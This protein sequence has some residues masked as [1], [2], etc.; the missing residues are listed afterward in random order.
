MRK[1]CC[2]MSTRIFNTFNKKTMFKID[3]GDNY[4]CPQFQYN[5]SGKVVQEVSGDDLLKNNNVHLINNLSLFIFSETEEEII[6]RS[7]IKSDSSKL[8]VG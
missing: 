2:I 1:K 4:V 5:I 3:A 6:L 8:L 7:S